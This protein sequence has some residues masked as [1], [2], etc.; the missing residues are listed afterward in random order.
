MINDNQKFIC[1]SIIEKESDE[2]SRFL[3][4]ILLDDDPI[5]CHILERHTRKRGIWLDVCLNVEEFAEKISSD[6]Y[7]LAILDYD[8]E[9]YNG[10]QI[11]NALG[12]LR[13]MI[14]SRKS[15]WQKNDYEWS[16]S[17]QTFVHKKYGADYI[18][19][20][21]INLGTKNIGEASDGPHTDC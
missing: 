16:A 15:Q 2:S 3:K 10:L 12:Q 19:D 4:M 6:D 5:F 18:L 8:L 21:A 20:V 11:A 17:I 14:I 13:S 9:N 7:D 1:D